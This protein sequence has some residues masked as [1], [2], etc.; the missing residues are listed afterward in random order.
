MQL[1]LT[2]LPHIIPAI[3]GLAFLARFTWYMKSLPPADLTDEELA[4][5]QASH[6]HGRRRGGADR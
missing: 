6:K 2:H 4:N 5:W 3:I 1:I